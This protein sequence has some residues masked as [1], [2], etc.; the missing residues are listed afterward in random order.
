MAAKDNT[1]IMNSKKLANGSYTNTGESIFGTFDYGEHLGTFVAANTGGYY[2]INKD[3]GYY[4][5][6][7]DQVKTY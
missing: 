2:L 5:V 4:F 3:G 7:S 1:K 6:N